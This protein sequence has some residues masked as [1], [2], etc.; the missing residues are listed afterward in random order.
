MIR[1]HNHEI[2]SSTTRSSLECGMEYC[3]ESIS[4]IRKIPF[5]F[6]ILK[7]KFNVKIFLINLYGFLKISDFN[8][9]KKKK[10][11]DYLIDTNSLTN[12][13]ITFRNYYKKLSYKINVQC[14]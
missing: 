2:V 11:P 9:E 6:K 5:I 4:E 13:S 7:N 10:L 12:L 14:R 1:D 8:Q 3:H